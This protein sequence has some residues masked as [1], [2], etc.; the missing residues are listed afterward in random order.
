MMLKMDGSVLIERMT[1]LHAPL[2]IKNM[3]DEH[4]AS[5]APSR[6]YMGFPWKGKYFP[7]K[8][9]RGE[10]KGKIGRAHV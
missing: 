3:K 7:I 2:G 8:V 1:R 10:R 6:G 9:I 5:K 4:E